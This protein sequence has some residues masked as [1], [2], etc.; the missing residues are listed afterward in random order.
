MSEHDRSVDP[1]PSPGPT[2]GP[3][4]V[5]LFGDP[6]VELSANRTAMSF[7]RTRMS[8]D[9]TL[10]SVI[11]TS[12][13]LIGFGFTIFQFFKGLSKKPA[14]HGVVTD[15]SARN[16]GL[17]LIVLGVGLLIA[18][19]IGHVRLIGQRRPRRRRLLALELLHS[20]PQYRTSP[21]ATVAVLLLIVGLGA[22]LG[23][24]WRAG[25]FG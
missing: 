25:P 4:N 16:F 12:L 1:G 23:M 7:E 10:M 20:G 5:M 2:P 3:S 18:G 14:L 8:T 21:T 6:A 15:Q 24:L 11:R 19:L 17:S 9:R 13:S 22:L